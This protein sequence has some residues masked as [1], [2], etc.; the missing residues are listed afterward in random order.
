M[1]QLPHDFALSN[2]S[3]RGFLKGVGAT[4]ALVLAASWG[5]QDAFAEDQ[6]FGAAG[7]P[8]GWIDD[9]KVYVS[10]AADGS[11]TAVSYTHLT[12][13]TSDLV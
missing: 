6:K 9:P 3:R 12:L 10:I 2:L 8:N 7:M 1:S 13:P 5:W 4:S 11:V